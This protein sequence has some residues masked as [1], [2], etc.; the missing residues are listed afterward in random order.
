MWRA[1]DPGGEQ[2]L[3]GSIVLTLGGG[4]KIFLYWFCLSPKLW[5]TFGLVKQVACSL[6]W[7]AP[8]LFHRLW[9]WF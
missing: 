2:G 8:G 5:L 3:P 7:R 4:P 9:V 6:A 1:G